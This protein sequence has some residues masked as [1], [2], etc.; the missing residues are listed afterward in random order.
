MGLS[1]LYEGN[2]KKKRNKIKKKLSKG[3]IVLGK[4]TQGTSTFSNY[5]S[6]YGMDLFKISM[7]P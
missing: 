2:G 1:V 5:F 4:H 6:L 7:L 3:F